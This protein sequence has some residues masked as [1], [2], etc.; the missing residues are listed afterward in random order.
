MSGYV[1]PPRTSLG[2]DA[3]EGVF[4]LLEARAALGQKA[5]SF[6]FFPPREGSEETMWQTFEKVL[7]VNAD[8]VSVT[9][10]AGGSN[11]DKSFEVLDRMAPEILTVGHLTC[12]GASRDSA[13]KTISRFQQA[14]VRSVL[15]LRGDAPKDNPDALAQ[16]EL[17]TALELVQLVRAETN[18]EVGVAAFPEGHPESPDLAHDAN[19]LSLKQA[20]GAAFAVTQLFFGVGYYTDLVAQAKAAGADLPIVPGLMP[21]SNAKQLLRMAA[22]SGAAVPEDLAH[23]LETADEAEARRIGMDYTIRLGLDLLEAGAPGLHIFT[24]NRSE[25][26]MELAAGVGLL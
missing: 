18:L 26:A 3:S 23:K 9:Y 15:A 20:Q 21:V 19:V 1:T 24:L 8:F 7:E 12:V 10:G 11:Q 6:E 4:S 17:K 22:M 13:R 14:G 16:G 5:L 25:A 2:S